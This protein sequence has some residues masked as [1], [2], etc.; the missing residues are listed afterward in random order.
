ML[1]AE[2][3]ADSLLSPSL[4][5]WVPALGQERGG[6]ETAEAL[7][8]RAHAHDGAMGLLPGQA[9]AHDD[10]T[11]VWPG[12]AHAYGGG[13]ETM[14]ARAHAHDAHGLTAALLGQVCVREGC[15]A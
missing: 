9:H 7:L 14:P 15:G 6:S 4:S 1:E 13:M 3:P 2:L 5:S 10:V 11:G 8:P 12:Q